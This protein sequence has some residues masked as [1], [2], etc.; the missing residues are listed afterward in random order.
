MKNLKNGRSIIV[1]IFMIFG[2]SLAL[3][4]AYSMMQQITWKEV[5]GEVVK[6]HIYHPKDSTKYMWDVE[7]V[8]NGEKYTYTTIGNDYEAEYGKKAT[9]LV[10]PKHP[11]KATQ[12]ENLRNWSNNNRINFCISTSICN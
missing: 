9:I 1:I 7:Y 6:S 5:E 8:M 12:K 3:V 10:N 2:F 11:E 4:G